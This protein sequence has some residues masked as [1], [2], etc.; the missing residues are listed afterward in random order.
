MFP[1]MFLPLMFAVWIAVSLFLISTVS[2]T[3]TVT[4]AG[5]NARFCWSISAAALMGAPW[6]GVAVAVALGPT[7]A[8][9]PDPPPHA[10]ATS[11]SAATAA[12]SA[13]IRLPL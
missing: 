8:A 5:R 2:P 12:T 9:D 1:V 11:T 4:F 3:F 7:G 10:A 6:V 13:A